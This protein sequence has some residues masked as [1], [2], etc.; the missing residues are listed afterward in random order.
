M[1]YQLT[2]WLPEKPDFELFQIYCHQKDYRLCFALNQQFKC[3]FV[4]VKDFLEEEEKPHLPT[5]AQFTYS[6]EVTHKKYYLIANQPT[7]KGVIANDG[8]LFPTEQPELLIP[9]FAKVDYFFQLYGQFEEE[10]ITEIE[11]EL[12]MISMIGL[13]KRVDPNSHKAYLNLMH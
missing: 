6:D 11:E 7:T 8:D 3:N 5:Y 10:E 12:N 13:A 9:E 2:D 1:K 4:R